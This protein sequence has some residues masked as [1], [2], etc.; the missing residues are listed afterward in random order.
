MIALAFLQSQ[1]LKQAKGGGA[2][3][4][5]QP[6]LPCDRQSSYHLQTRRQGNV[7]TAGESS[8]MRKCQNDSKRG[9]VLSL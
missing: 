3:P 4:P 5:P 1:G 8:I 9:Y 6:S 7:R 2:G